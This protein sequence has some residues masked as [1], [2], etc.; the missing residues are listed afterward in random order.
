MVAAKEEDSPRSTIETSHELSSS[1]YESPL[2]EGVHQ[3][4]VN[5]SERIKTHKTNILDILGQSKA[6]LSSLPLGL[7]ISFS[8]LSCGKDLTNLSTTCS[9][10]PRNG[11]MLPFRLIRR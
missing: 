11:N 6:V 1:Q 4:R 10:F 8:P 3:H 5:W 9:S 7:P 2:R